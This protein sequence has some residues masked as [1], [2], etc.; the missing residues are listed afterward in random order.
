M[1]R[2]E[3]VAII[4][5]GLIGGSIGLGLRQRGLARRVVGI[6]RNPRR[7]EAARDS[8]AVTAIASQIGDGVCEADLIVV[9][10][11]VERI[12]SQV[13]AVAEACPAHA[14]IT[15]VGSTKSAICRQLQQ[16]PIATGTFVGSH[17]MAGS[18]KSGV[19]H[20]RADL[21]EERV[22]VVTPLEGTRD[23]H[24]ERVQRF[25]QSLGS[26]VVCMSPEVHDR[27][28]AAISHLPHVIASALSAATP[29]EHLLLAS[30]GW[31]DTTRIAA[32]E[33]ELWRQIL[34]DNRAH[35]LQ[36]LDNFAKVLADFREALGA[37][38]S[39]QLEQLLQAGKQN[40]DAL[41]G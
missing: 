6:G 16:C 4:G 1:N 31:R 14:L 10:T 11:P 22:T 36:S 3:T 28:V 29:P 17:P 2:W 21:F 25:W 26:R 32:G 30:S 5:V 8:G 35:V 20:A 23:E 40:R 27:A 41:G 9:C 24:V 38:D 12:V 15:D 34:W 13:R 7:L 19:H 18:E 37:D 33:V 39:Q